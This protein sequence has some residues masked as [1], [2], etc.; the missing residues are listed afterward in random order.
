MNVEI[1]ALCDAATDQAG[2]LNLLG[3]FDRLHANL[4][5]VLPQ[6]AAAFRIRY[7]RSEAG[8][9]T[10]TLHLEDLQGNALIPPLDS[11][12]MFP[13]MQGG[14]DSQAVNLVLNMQRLRIDRAGKYMLR[15]RIDLIEA[16]SLPL[17]MEDVTPK[18]PNPL[19]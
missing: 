4:P 11:H 13:P 16:V 10:L 2:K 6:C 14:Y 19:A 5:L 15:L 7:L 18:E 12:V 17:W 3:T 1:A 8:E 9:H